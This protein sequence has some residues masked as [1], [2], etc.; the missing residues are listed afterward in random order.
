M[1]IKCEMVSAHEK[2]F[3]CHSVCHE[4][5]EMSLFRDPFFLPG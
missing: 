5:A 4:C 3:D 2:I 1:R